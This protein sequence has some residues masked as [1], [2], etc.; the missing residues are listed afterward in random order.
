MK[1]PRD[2]KLKTA[3][4]GMNYFMV[5]FGYDGPTSN[6]TEG[7]AADEACQT[8]SDEA[9]AILQDIPGI[10]IAHAYGWP[11]G[12]CYKY[13]RGKMTE[14]ELYQEASKRLQGLLYTVLVTP[15]DPDRDPF[16]ANCK[17]LREYMDK[18][19]AK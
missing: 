17:T 16:K 2:L 7:V 6:F 13:A 11:D 19:A 10:E 15:V 9:E 8:A 14:R 4:V 5:Q 1:D 18:K 3:E 12:S